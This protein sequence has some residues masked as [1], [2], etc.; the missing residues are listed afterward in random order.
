MAVT[1]VLVRRFL[2]TCAPEMLRMMGTDGELEPAHDHAW[3]QPPGSIA[4]EAMMAHLVIIL[5]GNP[6]QPGAE[7]QHG[8][9]ARCRAACPEL[10]RRRFP[11]HGALRPAGTGSL[12]CANLGDKC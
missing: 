6:S 11:P 1:A 4:A 2:R 8:V 7:Y 10:I 12:P 5:A 3:R 9:S